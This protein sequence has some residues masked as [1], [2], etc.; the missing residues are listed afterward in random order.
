LVPKD[1]IVVG[2]KTERSIKRGARLP[3]GQGS[4]WPK[5]RSKQSNGREKSKEFKKGK[6]QVAWGG[7]EPRGREVS[8]V[9]FPKR[10]A[11]LTSSLYGKGP[12]FSQRGKG[13]GRGERREVLF[14]YES[15]KRRKRQQGCERLRREGASWTYCTPGGAGKSGVVYSARGKAA[16]W[17]TSRGKERGFYD[18]RV[19]ICL[20]KKGQ[21]EESRYSSREPDLVLGEP[22]GKG[23]Y[24]F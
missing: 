6:W 13:A 8:L 5:G 4:Q 17:K 1:G 12:S 14:F 7:E 18:R 21:R 16:V 10:N 15:P 19:S 9:L 24:F 22:R 2:K 20:G 11:G 3:P 23:F